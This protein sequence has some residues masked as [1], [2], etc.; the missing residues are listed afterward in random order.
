MIYDWKMRIYWQLPVFLQETA[1]ISMPPRLEKL[2]YGAGYE[3]WRHEFTKWQSWSRADAE[4]WQGEQLQYLVELAATR[5]PYYR[6]TWQ[7]LDW[8]SVRRPADL[9]ILPTL[10][11]QALRQNERAFIASQANPQSVSEVS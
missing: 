8:K 6:K 10:H 7:K 3:T 4:A 11:K 1:L 5:V 9:H 2:Y